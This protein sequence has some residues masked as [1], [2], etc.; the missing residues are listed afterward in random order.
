MS[1]KYSPRITN[2]KARYLYQLLEEYD[3]GIVL[4]GAE[5]KSI[6]LGQANL[7]D[8][9]CYLKKGELYIKNMHVSDYKFDRVTPSEPNRERKLLLKRRE[10]KKL[11]KKMLEKGLTIVPVEIFFSERGFVKLRIALAKG[12]KVHDK[13]D[14]I[15]ERDSK[16]DMDR[17]KKMRQ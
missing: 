6:R 12:K 7:T 5:V 9:Y 15:K 16:R 8:S 13:R 17:M 10:L 3:V 2:K 4:T 11:E 14:S 1:G